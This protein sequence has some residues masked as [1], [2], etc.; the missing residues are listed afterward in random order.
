MQETIPILSLIT[1]ILAVIF[2]PIISWKIAKR[3]ITSSLKA[4]NKQIVAPMRQAWINSLRD[5]IA[6]ISSSALHYYQTGF[7]DRKDEEYK[8]LTELEGKIS[9]MLNFRE[10][11]HKKLHDFIRNMLNSLDRGKEGN[12]TFVEIHPKV[13]ALC[14]E[15][16][17]REWNRVKEDIPQT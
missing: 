6:E 13:L 12:N 9:L 8:R 3:Q 16:L 1:T 14:R 15:I 11:D 5:L 7:E 10:D 4:A 2:G 17:K